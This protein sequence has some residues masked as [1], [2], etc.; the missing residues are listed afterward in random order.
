MRA[1]G[2]L[3]HG[4]AQ[5]AWSHHRACFDKLSTSEQE[6]P[7]ALSLSKGERASERAQRG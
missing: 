5:L 3:A 4:G 6:N 1:L 2:R 7:L